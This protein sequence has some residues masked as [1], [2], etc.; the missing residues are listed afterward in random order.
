ME[1]L[2]D[3]TTTYAGFNGKSYLSFSIPA[4]EE[5]VEYQIEMLTKN[6]IDFCCRCLFKD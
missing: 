2:H 1:S 4:Q 3:F 5:L 6:R